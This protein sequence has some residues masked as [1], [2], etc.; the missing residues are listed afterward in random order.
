MESVICY[1]TLFSIFAMLKGV[2]S[3]PEGPIP[4]SLCQPVLASSGAGTHQVNDQWS[5]SL[6]VR[7]SLSPSVKCVS[8]HCCAKLE[9]LFITEFL[10]SGILPTSLWSIQLS[11]AVILG[12]DHQHSLFSALTP[13]IKR[14]TYV[15]DINH[16]LYKSQVNRSIIEQLLD[17]ATGA[18][19]QQHIQDSTWLKKNKKHPGNQHSN[20]IIFYNTMTDRNLGC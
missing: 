16:G 4:E 5:T 2:K 18:I 11:S 17:V 19:F 7:K 10:L 3:F 12:E 20:L 13:R 1:C 14:N 9:R 15:S 6:E 8:R